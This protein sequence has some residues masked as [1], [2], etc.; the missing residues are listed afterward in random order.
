[1]TTNDR[2]QGQNAR[3]LQAHVLEQATWLQVDELCARVHVQQQW[4][5]ELVELG[6]LEP[7][8]GAQPEAWAFPPS[9]VPRVHSMRRLVEDLGVNLPGAAII[10]ELVEERRRLLAKLAAYG[11]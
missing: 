5:M 7:R 1:M 4:I 8:G 11:I 2:N 9:D 3:V 10:L 6:A